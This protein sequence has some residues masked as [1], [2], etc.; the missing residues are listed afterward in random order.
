MNSVNKT[1]Y[2]PL[3][4]KAYVSRKGILLQDPKAEEIWKREGFALKGKSRSKW[5]AYYM[6]MRAAVFDDWLARQMAAAPE[7]VILHLGCGLDNRCGRV[8]TGEHKWYDIDFPEVIAER[9]RWFAQTQHHQMLGADLRSPRWLDL[10]PGDSAIVVMEGVSMY[11]EPQELKKL[12][13]GLAARFKRVQLLM[14]CYTELAAKA[15]R[16]RN[17]IND[18]GV[19]HVYGLDDPRLL[20]SDAWRFCAEHAMTPDRLVNALEGLEKRIF[21]TLYAGSFA[22]KLYR[23]YAYCGSQPDLLCSRKNQTAIAGR[24]NEAILDREKV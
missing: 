20:E 22:R 10:I 9:R 1:L 4:G 24:K 16:L 11:L 2:I 17:P 19:T 13:E 7:A 3:Y 12:L 18:V 23:L 14:D 8:G 6:G 21:R 15:S 5:L